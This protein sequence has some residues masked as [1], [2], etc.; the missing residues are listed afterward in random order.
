MFSFIFSACNENHTFYSE[1]QFENK[2]WA[3]TDLFSCEFEIKALDQPYDISFNIAHNDNFPFENIYLKITD[4]FNGKEKSDTISINLSD[5]FGIWKGDKNGNNYSYSTL[6]RKSFKFKKEK[7]FNFKVE[8]FT[9]MDS[10]SGIEGIA[11]IINE[12]IVK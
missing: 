9:R 10:L 1:K 12:A 6:L 7:N 11:F 4:D 5:K 8:Q 2:K 3:L